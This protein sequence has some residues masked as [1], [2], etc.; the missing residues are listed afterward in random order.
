MLTNRPK[1]ERTVGGNLTDLR[2]QYGQVLASQIKIRPL[3]PG[4]QLNH[5]EKFMFVHWITS[6]I[7]WRNFLYLSPGALRSSSDPMAWF[8][9]ISG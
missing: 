5:L 4:S 1:N 2:G 6:R 7:S 3:I 9:T 8:R